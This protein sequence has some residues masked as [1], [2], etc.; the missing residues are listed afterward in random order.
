MLHA[1]SWP[2]RSFV[3]LIAFL[4]SAAGWS[5]CRSVSSEQ[6]EAWKK[7]P[8]GA[9]RLAGVVKDDGAPAALRGEAAAAL[10]AAGWGEEMEAAV[11]G[12]EM[13]ERAILI[14]QVVPRVAPSLDVSDADRSGEARDALAALR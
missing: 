8:D 5:G 9:E 7:A 14:P 2:A 1:P 12:M 6:I 11:A 13:G 3:P 10:V 4:L